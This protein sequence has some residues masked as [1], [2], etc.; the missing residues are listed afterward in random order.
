MKYLSVFTLLSGLVLTPANA[1][2][3]ESIQAKS[4]DEKK[5]LFRSLIVS[6]SYTCPEVTEML[7]KGEDDDNAGYWAVKCSDGRDY[8][9][10]F[11]NAGISE[12]IVTDCAVMKAIG[13]ECWVTF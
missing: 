4:L 7:F 10:T 9:L 13:V 2:F 6:V 12:T 3:W 8:M 5:E 1:A 11:D